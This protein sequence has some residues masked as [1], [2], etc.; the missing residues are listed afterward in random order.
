M[1]FDIILKVKDVQSFVQ[2][3]QLLEPL[4]ARNASACLWF[5]KYMNEKRTT[6]ESLLLH[7]NFGV[8]EQFSLLLKTAINVTAKNEESYFLE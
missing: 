5:I 2:W 1:A 3:M 4:F 7:S 8:R 6:F